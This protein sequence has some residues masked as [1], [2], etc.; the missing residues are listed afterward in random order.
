ME[1][2]EVAAR[3]AIQ[4]T[5]ADYVRYADQGRG[6]ALADLFTEDGVL[7]AATDE[8]R[9]RAAIAAYLD[10][11]RVDLAARAE[12][13]GRIRHHLA[14]PS[15]ELLGPAAAKARTYF[16]AVTGT[17]PDHWGVYRDRLVA[18]DGQWRFASRVATVEG[19]APGGWAA[20]RRPPR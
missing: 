6:D 4:A 16:L 18:V 7:T 10:A 11:N 1:P 2:W 3:L 14:L 12:A 5:L 15:I 17:G 9:G 13:P 8:L 19:Q 20:T